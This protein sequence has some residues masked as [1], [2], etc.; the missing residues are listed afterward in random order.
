MTNHLAASFRYGTALALVLGAALS[1]TAPGCSGATDEYRCDTTGCY[2]CDGF[3]C[4]AVPAPTPDP[5]SFAGDTACKSGEVCTKYGCLAP[6][7]S[8]ATCAKG[9]VCKS[10]LCTP[11]T[12]EP[13]TPLECGTAADCTKLGDGA[14]CVDGK[15]VAKPA[16]T[17]ASCTCTYSSDCGDGRLCADGECKTACGAGGAACPTGF[18]CND[19]GFCVEGTPTCGASAGGATCKTGEKCVDGHCTGSCT[20]DA[21]CGDKT[22][23]CLGGAC[24]PDP[25]TDPTCTTS[26]PSA[27][28]KCVSGFCKYTCA[29]DTDCLKID[30]RIGACSP[31]EKICRAPAELTVACKAKSD[32]DSGKSCVDGQCK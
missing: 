17:D 13:T 25:R 29:A 31:T 19:K 14:T 3:G 2:Q 10:G 27:A 26:C 5:C 9:L 12:A 11:P 15:C 30:T 8:D 22:L 7:T 18:A 4:R 23:R 21:S 6:C 24:V 28:Q 1:L 20:D 16:C 32:C